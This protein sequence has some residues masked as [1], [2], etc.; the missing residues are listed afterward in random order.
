[1]GAADG[2]GAEYRITGLTATGGWYNV[3]RL[4]SNG[5]SADELPYAFTFLSSFDPAGLATVRRR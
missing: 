1:M 4:T 3:Q 2:S 5:V